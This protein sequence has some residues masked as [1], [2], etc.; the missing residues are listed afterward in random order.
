MSKS[1]KMLLLEAML[2]QK[3]LPGEIDVDVLTTA[4][5]KIA[6]RNPQYKRDVSV[7]IDDAAAVRRLLVENPIEAWAGGRGTGGE[8]Y[9]SFSERS[10]GTTFEV[11]P[12]LQ[13]TFV[14]MVRE[15]I[16][17]RL[18]QYLDRE[19][20]EPEDEEQGKLPKPEIGLELW[21][22]YSRSDIARN[23]GAKFNPGSWNSGIVVVGQDMVLLVTLA[24]GNLAAGNQYVDHFLDSTTFQWQSQDRTTAAS[25]HGRIINGSL[26]RHR[27]HLF[28]R[29]SKL[30]GTGAAPFIYCGVVTFQSWDGEKP[31]TVVWKLPSTVPLHL[32]RLFKIET[33]S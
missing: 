1:Y 20:D 17:W 19:G 13:E 31:I 16:E 3:S 22:E 27:V 15:I 21:R 23:L 2:A 32:R 18:A 26:P 28:V 10:F 6:E 29:P 8:A 4:F 14:D 11:Q 9:F 25:R 30:R 12:E 24:K 7:P 5:I 33:R